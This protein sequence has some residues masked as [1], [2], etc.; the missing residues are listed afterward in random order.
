[1]L[2]VSRRTFIALLCGSLIVLAVTPSV[3]AAIPAE[4]SARLTILQINDVYEISPVEKGKKGGLAR[5]ATLRDRIARESPNLVFVLPGDFLSPS[6]MS[7]LFQG[8]Q[9]VATLNATGLDLATFGN[10]EFD[11]G[12][13]ATRERMRESR[14]TW[15]SSNVLDPASGLPFGGAAPF[16]LREVGGIRVA[17]IGLVTPETHTLSKG[18]SGLKFLDPIQAA[19]EVV[20]RARRARADVIV[21]LTHQDMA[22]DKQ[23]AAAVPEID[24]ILG[25]HEHVPLDARVGRTLILKTGS[26]AV[27]LGRIDVTVTTGKA[28]RKIESKWELIPVTDQIPDKPEVAALVKQYEGL[29]A[30]ELNVVVG[31]TSVPL[32]TR[33]EIVRTQESAVGNLITDLMRAALQ[34]DVALINGGG[35]RGNTVLPAGQIRRRD[36]LTILPFANKVVKLDVTGET[37]RAALENGLS[38]VERTAG[39]FPQV[40]GIRYT[41]D[42]K[43]AAGSRLVSVTVGGRPL[44]TQ[45]RY[46]LATFDFILGGGDGYTMLKEGK[47]L[48]KAENGPMDSDVLIDRLKAGP[49]APVLDGRI[50]RVP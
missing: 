3:P 24:L 45:A 2:S 27:S 30:A 10:H 26:D 41:F 7:S 31:A 42:P 22:D 32:D 23:L 12:L 25:G 43:R 38:Q 33:N 11:F 34:A 29:M 28:G 8:S 5:V 40:S 20:A 4:R 37:L 17:F 16:V 21:A 47:V 13:E 6:T 35:I 39:R 36:V 9:M 19:K 50:Q 18:A 14:F 48:V 46:T 49:I 15:V 1:M 44:E